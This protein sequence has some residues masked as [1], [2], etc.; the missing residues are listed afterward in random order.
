[1]GQLRVCEQC[2][3]HVRVDEHR[4]PFCQAELEPR[5]LEPS[6]MIAEG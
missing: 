4:C 3:C 1:M 2:E 6:P 5:L